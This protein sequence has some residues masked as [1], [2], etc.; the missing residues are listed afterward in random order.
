M[1]KNIVFVL[2]TLSLISCG[3]MNVEYDYDEQANFTA[4]K[5]YNYIADMQSGMSQLDLNRLMQATDSILQGRGYS[6]TENPQLLID[7]TS[8]QY[9]QASRNTLGIGV[10]GG[11]GNV[12]VGVG[13]GI[14]IGGR[15]LHQTITIN[16]VDAQKD[17][18]IWQAVSDSNI[19]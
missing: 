10:G 14:P 9:Q 12:G 16:L 4:F 6:L 15:E 13:G 11:G 1:M 5:T 17:A 2:L 19:K 8:D 18:L 3:S 7:V